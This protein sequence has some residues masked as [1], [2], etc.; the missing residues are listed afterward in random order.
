M[1]PPSIDPGT[2]QNGDA[3]TPQASAGRISTDTDPHADKYNDPRV[4]ITRRGIWIGVAVAVLGMIGAAASIYA[5]RTHL[6]QTTRFWGQ[7]TIIALQLGERIKLLPR[8]GSEFE[9]VELTGTPGL[10]LLR[11]AL[12]DERGFDWNTE[13]DRPAVEF[14]QP[15]ESEQV[16]CV[17]LQITDPT[18]HRVGTVQ[19][20]LD[21]ASGWIGPADGSSRVQATERMQ[22][23]L[24]NYFK[25]IINVQQKRY[26]HRD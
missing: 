1:N 14:C 23:K 3:P 7:E 6:E 11:R 2:A 21:L 20:D 10:G 24:R 19:I 4:S 15:P 16:G 8:G 22:P 12:L 26:D 5:R 25:T 13:I 9:P 17:Q 18:A